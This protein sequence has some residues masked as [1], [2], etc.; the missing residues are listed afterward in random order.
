VKVNIFQLISGA[1]QAQG[2]AVIIDVFRAFSLVCYLFHRRASKIIAVRDVKM[3]FE[4]RE[5]YPRS[6]LV[7]ERHALKIPGFDYGNSPSEILRADLSGRTVIHTT[8]SGT[9]ALVAAQKASEV[10]TGSFVNADAIV[11]YINAA[12]PSEVSLVCS[13]FE[14]Q[15]ETLEDTLCAEY[16]REVLQGHISNFE[17]MLKRIRRSD[18]SIR[19][20]HPTKRINPPEDWGLCLDLDRFDFVVR[21][22]QRHEG[23]CVLERFEV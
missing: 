17:E 3:A 2:L 15:S 19:F 18:C 16:L 23:L 11:R 12:S 20:L 8:H 4:L 6:V 10:I 7:G 14:G 9:Q 1:Q 5:Q 21:G 13:G 22:A